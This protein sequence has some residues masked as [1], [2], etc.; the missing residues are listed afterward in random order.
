M[1]RYAVSEREL[2][3]TR[4][5]GDT[6]SRTVAI[7]AAFGSEV[8][9]LHVVR[10]EPG[11]SQPRK[12]EGVQEILYAAA[13]RGTLLVDG[14]A[15]ELEPGTAAYLVA[16]ESY[17][18]GGDIIVA[19]DGKDV[20]SVDELRQA[21]AGHKPGDEVKLTVVHADGKRETVTVELGSQPEATTTR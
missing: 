3:G 9:A 7:D 18:L 20:T 21:I 19:I 15:H 14:E 5:E 17:D 6:A 4:G 2:T 11:R 10:F 8:L 16:G 13:G 12:L 1:R